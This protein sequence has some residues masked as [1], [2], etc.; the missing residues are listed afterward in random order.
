MLDKFEEVLAQ[1]D[2]IRKLMHQWEECKLSRDS[3]ISYLRE[4]FAECSTP[5]VVDNI[6]EIKAKAIEDFAAS[7]Q[8]DS[9]HKPTLIAI[10][11]YKADRIRNNQI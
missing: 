5:S 6:N 1:N 9:I 8:R 4:E 11:K 2:R 7:V 10:A 3:L